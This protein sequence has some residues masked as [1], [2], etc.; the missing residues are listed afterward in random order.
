VT[1]P[2]AVSPRARYL[3][4]SALLLTLSW[5]WFPTGWL[6]YVALVPYLFGL[7]G[8]R[9]RRAFGYGF[10]WG[11]L[12][13]LLCLYW[14]AL[15]NVGALVAALVYLAVLD[16]LL[17]LL[18][19]RIRPSARGYL[20]PFLWTGFLFIKSVGQMGFPWL[21][22]GLSQTWNPAAI[23]TASIGG[24]WLVDLWVAAVNGLVFHGLWKLS[25]VTREI[26]PRQIARALA[27]A[28]ALALVVLVY[29][30]LV[31][32]LGGAGDSARLGWIDWSGSDGS[33]PVEPGGVS[34]SPERPRWV[35]PGANPLRVAAIQASL[36]PDVKLSW[37]LLSYNMYLYERY[38]RVALAGAGGDLDLIVWPE[39][40][41]PSRLSSRIYTRT[42]MRR[43]QQSL[44]V[45]IVT[46]AFMSDYDRETRL[47]KDY[48][49][50]YLIVDGNIPAGDEVY[51][52]RILVPFGE[53]V[54][55]QKLFGFLKGLDMG[56]SDFSLGESSTPL[57]GPPAAPE[58]PLIGVQIC[59]ESVFSRLVR[60]QVVDGATVLAV[61]TN[62]AWF[63][64]T[65]GP[66]QHLK[67]AALRAVEF[68]RP[69]I[70]AANCGV[71][72]F[73][74]RWGQVLQPT[75]LFEKT[76][77]LGQVWPE[78]GLTFYARTGDWVPILAVFV[79]LLGVFLFRLS[80][81]VPDR[82]EKPGT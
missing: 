23:Q 14:I 55:Y 81:T 59:Y 29:G 36:R 28:V 25:S 74:D 79:S 18:V 33:T 39:T 38:S 57:G 65:S 61:I 35:D 13:N 34:E 82:A 63:G 54:P 58:L 71:S 19:C 1:F 10:L 44:G 37:G 40:A 5:P 24:A 52:K 22:L 46:G 60:S 80:G 48:N 53:R 26:M 42:E 50:A 7:D 16:G 45:P 68:R 56:W 6:A 77:V 69:V 3:L 2:G 64:R 73:I 43:I 49:A 67:A 20:F 66:Y 9:G 62:D 17:T 47:V 11:L 76:A 70:R 4:A 78:P 8:L 21:T 41:V 32:A 15:V 27:P 12:V 51:K 75:P 72:G 30:H 31:L